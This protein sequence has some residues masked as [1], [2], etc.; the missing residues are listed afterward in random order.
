[1]LCRLAIMCKN[2]KWNKFTGIK[3]KEMLK[4]KIRDTE[5]HLKIIETAWMKMWKH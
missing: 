2:S 1:M 5:I 3:D 4:E